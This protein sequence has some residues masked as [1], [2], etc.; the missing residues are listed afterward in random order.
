M[1]RIKQNSDLPMCT[2]NDIMTE[3]RK[4]LGR[5]GIFFFFIKLLTLFLF[6]HPLPNKV[7]S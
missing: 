4:D 2:M 7:L 5:K 1:F 6:E 3:I